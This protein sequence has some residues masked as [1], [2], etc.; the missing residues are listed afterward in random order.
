MYKPH[1]T[2]VE[3]TASMKI[4]INNNSTVVPHVDM[5]EKY[6]IVSNRTVT[7]V[8]DEVFGLHRAIETILQSLDSTTDGHFV[9][10]GTIIDFPRFKW[11][12]VSL[13]SSRHYISVASIK[14]TIDAMA[15]AKFN[16]LHW[17]FWDDQAIR[18][19]FDT[20]PK[21]WEMNSDGLSYSKSEISAIVNYATARGVRVVPEISLPG[22]A[23]A[24]AHTYAE[25]MSDPAVTEYPRQ[26]S[27]GVHLPIM[28][29]MLP[30]LYTFLTDCFSELVG[31]FVDDYIH[32]GGDEPDYTQWNNNSAI[33][34]FITDNKLDGNSGLQAYLNSEV[35]VILSGLGK[36][37]MGWDEILHPSLPKS[38]VIQSWRGHDSLAQAALEGYA[39]VLS[40]GFYIDQPQPSDYHYRNDPIPRPFTVDDTVHAG[41]LFESYEWTKPRGKGEAQ[42]GTL[43]IIT[44][45]NGV[46][47]AF[48]DYAG[49][50]RAEVV[51][52]DYKYGNFFRGHYD[53]YMSY[54]EFNID[55]STLDGRLWPRLFAVA[56]RLWSN[57]N[58]TDE[59]SMF[60]RMKAIDR[61][62][63][64]S[65]GMKN[66]FQRR[67]MLERFAN[68]DNVEPLMGLALY[69]EPMQ[70]YG[71]NWEKWNYEPQGEHYD[72]WERLNRFVDALPVE[73]Y[74]VKEMM[75]YAGMAG[76]WNPRVSLLEHYDYVNSVAS[77][78]IPLFEQSVA[79]GGPAKELA[80]AHMAVASCAAEVLRETFNFTHTEEQIVECQQIAAAIG[81]QDFDEAVAAIVRPTELMLRQVASII[82]PTT[83]TTKTLAMP[84]STTTTAPYGGGRRA[85]G[86]DNT[87]MRVI[88]E[89]SVFLIFAF[90]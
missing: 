35:E 1:T 39:S 53:N 57:A 14:R 77:L 64:Q 23:S 75:E 9:P 58:L 90:N 44:D 12:G 41:E 63:E 71:R 69:A 8:C 17:H 73:S 42:N 66:N 67:T 15:G 6:S 18:M 19:Q 3:Q 49:K 52:M 46:A 88:S 10:A 38:I 7:I 24:V 21:L 36:K 51:V 47:R 28:N 43:S 25:L 78:S 48:T 22:H 56:E 80:V 84:S 30:D 59:Q 82:P 27:W 87:M 83:T 5:N 11:R 55:D 37:M 89:V 68:R 54:T 40:T 50:S 65:L 45:V 26:Y 62:A 81:R 2:T 34:Q 16:V 85:G 32:I 72:M 29:P 13:D 76:D 60:R 4:V 70:Y 86:K 74:F 61:W 79:A 20:H 31:L 33:Q